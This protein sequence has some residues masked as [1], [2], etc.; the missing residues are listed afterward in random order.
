[1]IGTQ[2][3]LTAG[4]V[5]GLI[6]AAWQ[7]VVAQGVLGGLTPEAQDALNAFVSLLVPI[8]A[9]LFAARLSTPTSSPI[10]P[11]GTIVNE[12]SAELPTSTVT[13]NP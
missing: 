3:V 5:A 1:V 7:V 6:L 8:I 10:L 9:A 13:P 11:V 4:T 2:P 12:R